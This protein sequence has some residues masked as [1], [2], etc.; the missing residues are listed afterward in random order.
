M[1]ISLELRPV[2]DKQEDVMQSTILAKS[3]KQTL[4][5]KLLEVEF[6]DHICNS[7]FKF[8]VNPMKID[9][10]RNSADVD[11][12]NNW[13]LKSVNKYATTLQISH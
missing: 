4:P 6:N 12:K 3:I 1:T 8:Q 5:Q 7:F 9:N 11:L 10:F 2:G 13:W